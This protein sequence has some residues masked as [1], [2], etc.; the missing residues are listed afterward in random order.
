MSEGLKKL[1]NIIKNEHPTFILMLIC[2][3]V[4]I[5]YHVYI[6][7][8]EVENTF[9]YV[10][11]LGLKDLPIFIIAGICGFIPA[12]ICEF[13]IFVFKAV[14]SPEITYTTFIYLLVALLSFNF[15]KFKLYSKK[16]NIPPMILSIAFITGPFW[17]FLLE[18]CLGVN[19]QY[20]SFSRFALYFL[21]ALPESTLGVVIVWIMLIYTPSRLKRGFAMERLYMEDNINENPPSILDWKKSTSV[22]LTVLIAI[23]SGLLGLFGAEAATSIIPSLI[24]RQIIMAT[25]EEEGVDNPYIFTS[26]EDIGISANYIGYNTGAL[27]QFTS[28]QEK[29]FV[30][31]Y[32]GF[33]MNSSSFILRMILLVISGL[34][35]ITSLAN[36]YA[37]K[38]IGEPIQKMAESMKYVL[39]DNSDVDIVD[40]AR[41]IAD[42]DIHTNDDIED[43]YHN[44]DKAVHVAISYID[45]LNEKQKLEADLENAQSANEA[46]SSF[47]SNM[48]HEIRTPINSI[49]GL[50]E[51]ILRECKDPET[52]KYARN[53]KSSGKA[54]LSLVNDVLDFSK[55]EAGKMDIVPVEYETASMI[56]DLVNMISL[57]AMKKKL[58]LFVNVNPHLPQ[59]LYGDEVRIRQCIT[60][61][62]T[63]AVKYTDKG[64]ISL[65]IS[66]DA[67]GPNHIMLK[68]SVT[69]TGM[70]I[71]QEDIERMFNAFERVD[72]IKNRTTEGTGLG[73]SIVRHLLNLMDSELKVVS[74]YGSGSTFS[75]DVGQKVVKWDIIGDYSE[76]F[77][78]LMPEADEYQASFQAPD[79]NILIVDDTRANLIVAKGLLKQTRINIDTCESGKEMLEMV[80]RK[81]YDMIFID[82]R[83][84]E[85]DGIETLHL[86][87]KLPNNLNID[88]PCI[89]LTANAISGARE[90][91]VNEGFNDYMSK[92]I[93]SARLEEMVGYYLRDELILK[94]GHYGYVYNVEDDKDK[95]E[96][97]AN[98]KQIGG[99]G[100][101]VAKNY[102]EGCGIDIDSAI[103]ACGDEEI[104]LQVL[105]QFVMEI[106]DNVEKIETYYDTQDWKEYTVIVH[107]LKNSARMIGAKELSKMAENL[108][109]AGNDEDAVFIVDNTSKF[110]NRYKMYSKY[111]SA[112]ALK[113]DVSGKPEITWDEYTS[114]LKSIK[115]CA[116]AFDFITAYEIIKM[117]D[118]YSMPAGDVDDYHKV[119]R[120]VV[121]ADRQG[122]MS[123]VDEVIGG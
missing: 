105:K 52:L 112:F 7:R 81:K 100:S 86:M 63:N 22:K 27:E 106:D 50:D 79:A 51:M 36:Y 67:D 56:N 42:L 25:Y 91:Y 37:Q 94:P 19:I 110:L 103:T 59:V 85:M 120:M 83:M 68:V 14:N 97:A 121:N 102:F 16:R 33:G 87:K 92:P 9:V 32:T 28:N 71:K 54:L 88:T 10:L 1:K 57:R 82:H 17:G 3:L 20:M 61:I 48:S 38:R 111:L 2:I 47:L 90:M 41:K 8:I 34:V 93:E 49:L 78:T 118:A 35:P 76:R 45:S 24:N 43:L 73:M 64:T 70:G 40:R 23:L 113:E 39:D 5:Y 31:N 53:I 101:K 117:I 11:V 96:E 69:D 58:D 98:S 21:N 65:D 80:T 75:F 99:R 18:I 72:E 29:N 115:E 30:T 55:I 123:S 12:M 104:L 15:S 13:I 89:A 44:L 62:L 108:E 6:D 84:P 77:T 66:F 107:A 46:K 116:E 4:S 74:K 122:V 114:A 109:K 95:E 119:R 26:D 60:N